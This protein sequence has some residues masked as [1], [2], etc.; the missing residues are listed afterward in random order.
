MTRQTDLITSDSKRKRSASE[1]RHEKIRMMFRTLRFAWHAYAIDKAA[2]G[3]LI[4][5]GIIVLV[6][7][8]APYISPHDTN[9]AVATSYLDY[10][11]EAELR[12]WSEWCLP[13]LPLL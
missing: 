10:C 13:Q 3:A 9:D 1:L 8:L 11:G 7:I 2:V 12:S 4:F 6:S 5:M